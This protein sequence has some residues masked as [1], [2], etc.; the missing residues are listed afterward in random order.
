MNAAR[1]ATA[2]AVSLLLGVP[3]AS[4][5]EHR[6]PRPRVVVA[7]GTSGAVH[8]LDIQ[9]AR[10]VG[11]FRVSGP[12]ALTTVS[13]GRHVL[14]VQTAGNRVDAIDSGAWAADH[15]DHVHFETARPRALP[16]GLSVPT[17]IHVV[18]HGSEVAIF[19]DGDGTGHVFAL[20]ALR[21]KAAP[22]AVFRTTKPHHGV[23]VPAR[24]RAIVSDVAPDA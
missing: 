8:V 6:T 18:P 16:F 19:A 13:D 7:D 17:P 1:I 20:S 23:A 10:R 21:R 5:A 3:V 9:D 11:S 14:A 24:D 4:A 2:A 12:A 22:L 15:G